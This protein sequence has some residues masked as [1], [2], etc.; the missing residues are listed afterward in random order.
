MPRR[1]LRR[2][3][4][5]AQ[6]VAEAT[7]AV[8]NSTELAST[9]RAKKPGLAPGFFSSV[10]YGMCRAACA[11]ALSYWA[12]ALGLVAGLPGFPAYSFATL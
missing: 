5:A 3:A 4:V 11:Q 6:S 2:M 7:T 12:T 1:Q 10:R 9:E 8:T